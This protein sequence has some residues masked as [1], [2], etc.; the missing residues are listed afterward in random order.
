MVDKSPSIL[1]FSVFI[2]ITMG[3]FFLF[4]DASIAVIPFSISFS[5]AYKIRFKPRL[6]TPCLFFAAVC[7]KK[8]VSGSS[9]FL[10][11]V[12]NEITLLSFIAIAEFC[13]KKRAPYK[14]YI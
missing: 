11:P 5:T 14:V 12:T 7:H 1:L 2:N 6:A 8:Y 10:N 9:G 13:E 3:V 4:T